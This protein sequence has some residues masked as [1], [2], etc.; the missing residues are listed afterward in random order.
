[1]KSYLQNMLDLEEKM[2]PIKYVSQIYIER[3][4]QVLRQVLVWDLV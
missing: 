4:F 1:M 2:D 3:Q